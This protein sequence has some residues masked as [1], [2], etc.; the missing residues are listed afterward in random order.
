[1]KNNA[2]TIIVGT[3]GRVLDLTKKGFLKL[4]KL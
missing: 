2:P 4:D 3:P 1:L